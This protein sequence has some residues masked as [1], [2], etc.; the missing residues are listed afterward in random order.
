MT[1]R[2]LGRSSALVF[3]LG[4]LAS[5]VLGGC[6]PS[7]ESESILLATTTSTQDSGLLDVLLPVFEEKTGYEVKTVAV[8]TGEALAMGRRG[9]ADVLLVHAPAREREIV[10]SGHAVNRRQ[11]MH[12]GFLIVGPEDDP[13][14]IHGS[15]DG[16]ESVARI[17][18]ARAG[19]ASRGDDSGTHFREMSL[20]R[21]AGIE[22][23]GDWY[24]STGQGMGATLMIAAEKRAYVLTDRGTYLAWRDRTGLVPHV[25]ED[26]SFLNVYSVLEVNPARFP[27]VNHAGAKAFSEF[28]RGR[29]AQ[30]LIKKSLATA[31]VFLVPFA[32]RCGALFRS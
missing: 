9:D 2:P 18:A 1:P 11:V 12:N 13:A 14:G 10:E 22:P 31:P 27:M 15:S 21:K 26:P 23:S 6:G 24:V 16:A 17:A 7:N 25:E 28:L 5:L 29:E 8:G 20:W 19:F 30:E 4:L 3:F 32:R